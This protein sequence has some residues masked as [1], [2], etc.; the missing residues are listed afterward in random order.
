[1]TYLACEECGSTAGHCP[2]Y[3]RAANGFAARVKLAAACLLSNSGIGSRGYDNCFEM[4]D[5]DAVVVALDR[6]A[7]KDWLLRDAINREWKSDQ[8]REMWRR[9]CSRYAHVP[10]ERLERLAAEQRAKNERDWQDLRAGIQQLEL[11]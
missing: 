1:M 4:G 11:I 3:P 5:G 10:T 7:D 9:C 6:I 2:H 8:S